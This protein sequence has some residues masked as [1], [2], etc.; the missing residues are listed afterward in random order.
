[1]RSPISLLTPQNYLTADDYSSMSDLP[2]LCIDAPNSNSENCLLVGNFLCYL[3]HMITQV[4]KLELHSYTCNFG[5]N[6]VS[7]RMNSLHAGVCNK[8]KLI[9]KT[10]WCAFHFAGYSSYPFTYLYYFCI[11]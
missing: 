8:Y 11:I 6:F 7:K 10:Q 4:R 5:D 9:Y 1:M 2:D 3:S